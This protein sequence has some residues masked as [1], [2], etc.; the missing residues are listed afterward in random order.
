MQADVPNDGLLVAEVRLWNTPLIGAYLLWRFVSGYSA[1]ARSGSS[2]SIAL[3]FV[4]SAILTSPRLSDPISDRRADLQS[5]VRSFND[6]GIDLL[7][8]IQPRIEEKRA[9]TLKAIGVAIAQGIL[10]WDVNSGQ[11][12][13]RELRQ[14][15]K[16]GR[17]IRSTLD[18]SGRKAEIFGGWCAQHEVETVASYLKVVF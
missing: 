7:L 10:N 15:A 1:C 4:A 14:K 8:S 3:L 18:K 12:F 9:Y 5:Y 17:A 13:A 6:G 2:P 11:V 16:R